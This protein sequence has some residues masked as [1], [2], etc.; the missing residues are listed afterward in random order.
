MN[1]YNNKLPNLRYKK[2]LEFV[3]KNLP[4]DEKILDL[5]TPNPFTQIMKENGYKASNTKGENLDNDFKKI[6]EY[7]FDC[8]TSFEIFEHLLAPYNLLKEVSSTDRPIR[9]ISSVP[10][11]VWFSKAHWNNKNTWARH[12]HEFEARQYDWLLEEAGWKII[13]SEKWTS[14]AR[15]AF[16]LRPLLRF[17]FPSYYF[18]HAIKEAKV[19]TEEE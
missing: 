5:G 14:P 11:S 10:L 17:I 6:N 13:S 3:K 7:D 12:Y 19:T 4:K 1:M 16:G 2:T 9:L 15:F 8:L 18:V